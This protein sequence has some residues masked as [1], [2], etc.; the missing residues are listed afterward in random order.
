MSTLTLIIVYIILYVCSYYL[1][2]YLYKSN[3][4]LQ[5]WDWECVII[6]AV[7]CLTIF[8]PPLA[9]FLYKLRNIKNPPKWL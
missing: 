3:K 5:D 9:E 7:M 8:L 1:S 4:T 2:R 6:Y